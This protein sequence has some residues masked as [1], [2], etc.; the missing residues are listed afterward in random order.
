MTSSA[1]VPQVRSATRED[2][3][4]LIDLMAEFYAESSFPL[5]VMNARRAF[6][7]LLSDPRLGGV[8]IATTDAGA[9]G[10]AVLTVSFGMEYG[11]L[12]GFID[13]LFVRPQARGRGVASALLAAITEECVAR[14]V[15]S[16]NVEVGPDNDAA[17]RVYARAGLADS[18][19]MLLSRALAAPLHE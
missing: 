8:W 16:L 14:G 2:V 12:R 7:R 5:P 17:R 13:D 11:G 4:L 15:L 18:G 19:R 10:Y 3:P 6:E 9:A 1:S